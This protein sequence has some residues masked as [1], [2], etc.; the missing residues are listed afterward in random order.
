MNQYVVHENVRHHDFLIPFVIKI[1]NGEN[2]LATPQTHA[3]H[4][5]YNI[6]LH[7]Q[8]ELFFPIMVHEW[9]AQKWTNMNISNYQIHNIEHID[10]H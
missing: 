4:P 10:S 3:P 6:H 2:E 1:C 9:F 7:K 8:T 5:F